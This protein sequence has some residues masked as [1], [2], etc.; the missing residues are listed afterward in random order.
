MRKKGIMVGSI[1]GGIFGT[2][3][4]YIFT[5]GCPADLLCQYYW[6]QC[7]CT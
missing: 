5:P 6:G 1:I 3:R 4:L 7:V 2:S